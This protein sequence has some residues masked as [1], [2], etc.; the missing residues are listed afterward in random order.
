MVCF[1]LKAAEHSIF[2]AVLIYWL[3]I[4]SSHQMLYW[5]STG[6]A[7]LDGITVIYCLSIS[8]FHILKIE[9]SYIDSYQGLRESDNNLKLLKSELYMNI[10]D[11]T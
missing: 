9:N 2:E 8:L 10:I 6:K 3:H 5:A 4:V 7:T 11:S 1:A